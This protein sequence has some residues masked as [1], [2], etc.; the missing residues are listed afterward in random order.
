MLHVNISPIIYREVYQITRA[1]VK[2]S[3]VSTKPQAIDDELKAI[4]RFAAVPLRFR[5][6]DE[7]D[8][9]IARARREDG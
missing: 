1:R 9:V 4:I 2:R 8:A 3:Q 7:V 5:E 6:V